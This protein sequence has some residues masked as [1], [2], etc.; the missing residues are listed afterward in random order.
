MANNIKKI[1]K[2]E[3]VNLLLKYTFFFCFLCFFMIFSFLKYHKGFISRS[4]GISQHYVTLSYFRDFLIHFLQT[5]SMNTFV[6]N[7]SLGMDM[8]ANL[9]Y[10]I[11]GDFISYFSIFFPKDMVHI[12]F[13][14]FVFIRIYFIGLCFLIYSKYKK[15]SNLY[16]IIGALSYAFCIYALT[17]SV[18]H[19][20]FMNAL[21]MFPLLM[22]GIEKIVLENKKVPFII[23]IFFNFIS[24]FYFGYMMSACIAIYGSILIILNYKKEGIKAI[25]K[26]FLEV[27]VC[28]IIGVGM[29]AFLLLP[30]LNQFMESARSIKNIHYSYNMD[31]YRSLLLSPISFSGSN[32]VWCGVHGF[33]IL[34]LPLAIKNYK[35]YKEYL[36]FLALLF[37][38]LLI[39]GIGSIFCGFSFPINRW[40]YVLSFLFI[41]I[42]IRVLN[43]LKKITL[44]DI[45][46][47]LI[48]L[49]I[50][51]ILIVIFQMDISKLALV[52]IIAAFLFLFV[53]IN[54]SWL[55]QT[56]NKIGGF[57]T[58]FILYYI[59]SSV[60]FMYF[61]YDVKGNA[62]ASLTVGFNYPNKYYSTDNGKTKNM[63][64]A[65]EFLKNKDK[66]FYRISK[67]ST[68]AQN[69][70]LY[71]DYNSMNGYYSI[72]P[73][74]L[75]DM[76]LDLSNF[77]TETSRVPR[78]FNYRAKMLSLL[79]SKYYI[80]DSSEYLPYGYNKIKTIGSTSIY[81]NK[82]FVPIL[83]YYNTYININAYNKL[84]SIDKEQVLLQTT[85]LDEKDVDTQY[86]KHTNEINRDY[87]KIK[88]KV[89]NKGKQ[90]E[91]KSGVTSDGFTID[92]DIDKHDTGDLYLEIKNL[93]FIPYSK[94]EKINQ[95]LKNHKDLLTKAKATQKYSFYEPTT[96]FNI[97][98]NY[99]KNTYT[100]T[101]YDTQR[102][103]YNSGSKDILLNL[104]KAKEKTI[105][106]SFS[107]D[108]VYNYDEINIYEQKYTNFKEQTDKL[109]S[110]NFK[111]DSY[112]KG[113]LTGNVYLEE[114]GILQLS[115]TYTKGIQVYIDGNLTNT[116]KSNKY[117]IGFY[118]DKG[119]HHIE[120]RYTT[121]LLKEGIM[122]SI[123]STM[124]FAY[125]S[126]KERTRKR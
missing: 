82:Y 91:K 102:L 97:I 16:S 21:A 108:G 75:F 77:E 94:K 99:G 78:E 64:E 68:Y 117:F 123:I 2:K 1:I 121:P 46:F 49:I 13:Y 72:M 29:A 50:Y 120:I 125:I 44:S 18:K 76:G 112:G 100:K 37:I 83:A 107:A 101:Y 116:F 88:S 109:K 66:D 80:A 17:A 126:Y 85:A 86:I 42:G 119:K 113:F 73:N 12:A 55:N 8:F 65:I 62:Q 5:G 9:V 70:S 60:L 93:N 41:F 26:K 79:S 61:V 31:Y 47:I 32:W 33:T 11:I 23:I 19:P 54:K 115:T 87:E 89:N 110:T 69:L 14:I 6:W 53:Y 106:L 35:K 40:S 15:I 58:I 96:E 118:A 34:L 45:N 63:K 7:I 98:I 39:P 4:D 43:D 92:V 103:P 124:L 27:I 104:S 81:E 56:F 95:E 84:E 36:L 10:Y 67:Y 57:K 52:N 51:A 28:V 22:Y 3:K 30:T 48:F 114:K 59:F 71:Y 74:I 90:F 122:L 25:V 38:P 24:S 20:Y 105:T 111:V